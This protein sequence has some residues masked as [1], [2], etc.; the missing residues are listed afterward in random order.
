MLPAHAVR[1]RTLDFRNRRPDRLVPPVEAAAQAAYLDKRFILGHRDQDTRDDLADFLEFLPDFRG[2]RARR[3]KG[4]P[5]EE[6][7]N[8][9]VTG[10]A[11]IPVAQTAKVALN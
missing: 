5:Q 8:G 4:P 6:T 1:S 2:K 9:C 11:I 3:A 10:E 7:G